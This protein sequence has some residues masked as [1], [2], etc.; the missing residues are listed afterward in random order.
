MCIKTTNWLGVSEE[1]WIHN[2]KKRAK[3]CIFNS[4]PANTDFVNVLDIIP[5]C[6]I[7]P[8][9]NGGDIVEKKYL[10][11]VRDPPQYVL[12]YLQIVGHYYHDLLG[13]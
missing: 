5:S 8:F 3:K 9:E 13:T 10:K 1:T 7:K 6:N 2:N 12:C 11:L 4:S